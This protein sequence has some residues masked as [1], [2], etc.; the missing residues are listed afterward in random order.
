MCVCVCM[1][2]GVQSL[3]N[4]MVNLKLWIWHWRRKNG[5][6][7]MIFHSK[8]PFE[9]LLG[10][11]RRICF[12]THS[13]WIQIEVE[14]LLSDI[15][16]APKKRYVNLPLW[17]CAVVSFLTYGKKSIPSGLRELLLR[18]PALE[19]KARM[20]SIH[21]RAIKLKQKLWFNL[22]RWTN[23]QSLNVTGNIKDK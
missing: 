18:P 19:R 3:I 16:F 20:E 11:T 4:V 14:S 12:P 1:E 9:I 10:K 17:C 5:S 8:L 21:N 22:C 2:G 15:V 7:K 13:I 6:L 23:P